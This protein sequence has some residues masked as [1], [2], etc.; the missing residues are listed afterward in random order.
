MMIRTAL[1]VLIAPLSLTL[2]A[3]RG[4]GADTPHPLADP[5]DNFGRALAPFGDTAGGIW[6][7]LV[8]AAF[9]AAFAAVVGDADRRWPARRVVVG[10][11]AILGLLTLDHTLLML[12]GY[13]P[14]LVGRLIAGNT[15]AV[16]DLASPGLAVQVSVA[17]GVVALLLALRRRAPA[18]QP[19]DVG[20]ALVAATART[21]RW[22]MIAMEAPLVYAATRLLMF[23]EAPGFGGFDEMTRLAGLGLAFASIT[24]AILT[25]GL[26]RPWGERFPRWMVGLA[27]RRVP[28]DLAVIP[29]M[30]VAGLVLAASRAVLIG[31][32]EAPAG[33]WDRVLGSP[34]VS[35]PHLLW[36]LWGVSLALA[37]L[38][39]QRRRRLSDQ[40]SRSAGAAA[41]RDAGAHRRSAGVTS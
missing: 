37:A 20:S 27:G 36:P 25:W 17:V 35:L 26:M 7:V 15:D 28:V 30:A 33:A 31:M 5:D 40:L 32:L 2:A 13:L 4:F 29:A 19:A 3:A 18:E 6:S 24:G 39:Y 21:R 16:A 11:A 12:L 22:T 38:S 34:L 9:L 10:A 8:A 23:F 1:P 41:G 14:M